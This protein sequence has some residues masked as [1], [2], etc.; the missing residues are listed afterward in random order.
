[1][2]VVANLDNNT[3]ELDD[4]GVTVRTLLAAAAR[5]YK[6]TGK[7]KWAIKY[8]GSTIGNVSVRTTDVNSDGSRH[9]SRYGQIQ[10]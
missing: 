7:R 3:L 10:G 8:K 9:E 2:A 1:M 4:M 5:G 6:T